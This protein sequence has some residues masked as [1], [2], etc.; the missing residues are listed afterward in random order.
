MRT[1]APVPG[2]LVIGQIAR[3]LVLQVEDWPS[4]GGS[5]PVLER[6]EMLGGKGANQ[7]V[8]LHQLGAPVLLVGVAG[9]DA[10]GTAVLDQAHADG[11]DVTAVT[12]R[13]ETALLVDV[14]DRDGTRRLIEHVPVESLLTAQD[15]HEAAT[16]FDRAD[17]VCLQLQQPAPALLAGARMARARGQRVIL[18]GAIDSPARDELL[19]AA[20]VVRMDA[21]E[22]QLMT[23]IAPQDR[24]AARQAAQQVLDAGVRLV[25][26]TV[27][28]E[29]DLV[30]WA[31][32]EHL[33]PHG[34]AHVV[35]PTGA[36][37]AFLAGLAIGLRRGDSPQEAARRA[38]AAATATVQ[39]LG[40]RPD[41]G[42]RRPAE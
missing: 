18:D 27:P 25:A 11:L 6:R 23:G 4:A 21:A 26:V 10:A 37:D 39:R 34:T 8:A 31:E 1:T 22:A 42:A 13:G 16:A 29:G 7:A 9:T 32:G 24:D 35:D 12:R 14:V 41:L 20:D 5:A 36:G 15:V 2:V 19:A 17:T 40:G 28:E 3:D 30:V 38:G 33:V